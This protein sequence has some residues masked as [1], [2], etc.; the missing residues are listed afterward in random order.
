[1]TALHATGNRER[2]QSVYLRGGRYATWLALF[3]AV[4]LFVYRRELI[5]LYTAGRYPGAAPVLGLLLV[6]VLLSGNAM[7]HKVAFAIGNMRAVAVTGLL[8]QLVNVGLTL[9][10]VGVMKMGAIGSALA[11]CIV[12]TGG[13]LLITLPLGLRLSGARWRTWVAQT[14]IPGVIPALV[15]GTLW[16]VLRWSASPD[17]W[18]LLAAQA[19]CGALAYG[20]A[21]LFRLQPVEREELARVLRHAGVLRRCR[22]SSAME[23]V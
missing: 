19:L 12:Y 16:A 22:E 5:S 8:L 13:M 6:P 3:A 18:W 17:H 15:A 10:L 21:V 4:P 14:L 7:V 2:L 20:G 9:Y 1:M 23:K 11:T